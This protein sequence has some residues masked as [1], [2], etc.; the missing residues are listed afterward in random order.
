VR[1]LEA[2]GIPAAE[3]LGRAAGESGWPV[4]HV[5]HAG[6]EY[7][8]RV[9]PEA[10]ARR[11]AAV[12]RAAAA[13]GVP[14]PAIR[15]EAPGLLL[16]DWC[17]GITL[18]EA[19]AAHPESA[20][21]LGLAFGRTQARIHQVPA[22]TGLRPAGPLEGAALLHLDYH[23]LNVL[24]DGVAITAVLDW[25]NAGVGDPQADLARTLSILRLEGR[26][27]GRLPSSL[28][29][30]LAPFERGWLEGCGNLP[31]A[32]FCAWAGEFMA[33]DMAAKRPAD[34]LDR[35]R[36][37]AAAWRSRVSAADLVRAAFTA[38]ARGEIDGMM[39]LID[40]DLEWTYLDPSVP[41][42]EPQVCHGRQ[43]LE[44]SV[45]GRAGRGLQPVIE[46]I[47]ANGGR[48]LVVERIPGLDDFRA[49]K[50]NDRDY[51]VV[52][53][54]DSRIVT[55]RACRSRAEAQ[56]LLQSAG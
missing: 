15:A 38:Y 31:G 55:L 10:V 6:R 13:G 51:Y 53:V 30:A 2:V 5:A 9:L 4:W 42:P 21:G 27:P 46:E 44:D 22:P 12:H 35:V 11:E 14:V 18:I 17:P 24:T 33:E 36:R 26:D 45:R 25:T 49:R 56:R 50:S 28:R 43:R 1:E 47:T 32:A 8:L 19:L 3:V 52:T 29:R 16:T 34:Y 41:D 37:W 7:A 39:G 23:P 54:R 20:R 48:V 40:P